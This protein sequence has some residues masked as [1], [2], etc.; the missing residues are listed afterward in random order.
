MSDCEKLSLDLL[1]FNDKREVVI[2]D[3]RKEKIIYKGLEDDEKRVLLE[4]SKSILKSVWKKN[5]SGYLWEIKKCGLS[6]TKNWEIKLKKKLK[7]FVSQIQLI[8][9]MFLAQ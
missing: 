3:S 8:V 2:K 6:A 9:D 5:T 1:G 7:K 4:D